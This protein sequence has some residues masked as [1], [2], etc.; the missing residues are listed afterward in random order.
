MPGYTQ[1]QIDGMTGPQWAA[2][3][4]PVAIDAPYVTGLNVPGYGPVAGSNLQGNGFSDTAGEANGLPT[5]PTL[6]NITDAFDKALQ[7]GI[8]SFALGGALNPAGSSASSAGGAW[9]FITNVPRVVTTL[10]GL[11]L[12][13]AG[14][15][16]LAKGQTVIQVLKSDIT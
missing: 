10:L 13:I 5:L 7:T 6:P 12:I 2:L 1:A 11:V 14:V 9:A 4:G 15:F 3:G 8:G 16:A